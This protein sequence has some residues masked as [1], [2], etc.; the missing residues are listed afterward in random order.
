MRRLQAVIFDVD[1]TL[2]DSERD[3]HRVAFNLAFEEAGLPDRWDPVPYG[4]LLN[5]TGGRRRLV[6][7]LVARG[8]GPAEAEELARRLHTRKTDLMR[9]L[10]EVGAVPPRPGAVRLLTELAAARV[11]LSVATTGNRAWVE[12]LLARTFPVVRFRAVVTGT[13]I[14]VLKPDPAVY[15]EAMRLTGHGP[16]DCVAVEDSAAGVSAA[17]QAGLRCVAVTNDYTRDHDLSGAAYVGEGLDD[18]AVLEW[19]RSRLTT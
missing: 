17:V 4:Q 3:G 15:L 9:D 8:H 16:E 2:V 10:I 11:E 13:E 19:F 14:T 6:R 1:G 7:Y 12:P 5:V 18:P